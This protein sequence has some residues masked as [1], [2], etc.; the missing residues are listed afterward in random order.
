MTVCGAP[1]PTLACSI[2]ISANILSGRARPHT[3]TGISQ[4]TGSATTNKALNVF[5]RSIIDPIDFLPKRSRSLRAVHLSSDTKLKVQ[6]QMQ[7]YLTGS[8]A[9]TTGKLACKPAVSEAVEKARRPTQCQVCSSNHGP[10]N[11]SVIFFS[12]RGGRLPNASPITLC[13]R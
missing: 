10:Q 7:T 1:C 9:R 5:T 4:A 8:H 12:A 6:R 3:K 2:Q 11:H 13:R